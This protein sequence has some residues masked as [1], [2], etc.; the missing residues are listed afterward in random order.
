MTFF[1]LVLAL[2]ACGDDE[3][4]TPTNPTPPPTFTENFSGTLNRN[5][6]Q[7]HSFSSQA[8]GTVTA[9]LLSVAPDPEVVI[10]FSLGTWNGSLCQVILRKDSAKQ[11]D[12]ITGAVSSFGSLCVSVYDAAANVPAAQPVAYE[13]QVVHP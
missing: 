3:P 10:G 12:V 2:A 4:L 6:G 5:G 13:V 1:V 9:T 7:T 8:S 11:G